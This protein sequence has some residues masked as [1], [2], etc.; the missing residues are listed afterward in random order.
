MESGL[1]TEKSRF[2]KLLFDK[3]EPEELYGKA[4]KDRDLKSTAMM[5]SA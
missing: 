5:F 2:T 3:Y 4:I 1:E